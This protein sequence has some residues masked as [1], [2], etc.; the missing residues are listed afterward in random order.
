MNTAKAKVQ[1]LQFRETNER[2]RGEYA[3]QMEQLRLLYGDV[4]EFLEPV[5]AGETIPDCDA[6]VFPQL[7]GAAYHYMEQF[8]AYAKPMLVITSQFGTVDMW[9][10]ELITYMRSHGLTVFSPY[11]VEL[12]KVVMRAIAVKEHMK[13]AK[14]L[15]FQDDPGEGM[16]AYIFKRFYWWEEECTR[17]IEAA[18]GAK[19]LYR[20]WKAVNARAKEMDEKKAL[21]VFDSWDVPC[22]G[23]SEKSRILTGQ[24]YLAIHEVI[25]ELGGVDGIGANCLNES[26]YSETTP[27]LIWNALFE[28][29][30]IVWCC[31]GDTLSMVSTY[32]LY[33][34]LKAPV[35]MTNIYPFLVGKAA[36]YHEKIDDFP[37]VDDPA[38]YALGVHCGYAGFAPKCFCER[39]RALPK[40]LAIVNENA[41]VIDC[42]LPCGDMVLAKINPTFDRITVIPGKI[43]RYVQ[44]PDTDS[45]NASLLHY[46]KGEEVMEELPSHHQL[47]ITGKQKAPIMQ[48]AKVFGWELN[49]I[50]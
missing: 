35:M 4:A 43:E 48:V 17:Q 16:Q 31:E 3:Q 7:I 14:F 21:E 18:F 47:I 10:W 28:K 44:F 19:V 34:S 20:S 13:G 33:E 45:R 40:V 41:H 22:E 26:M 39:W 36:I 37:P 27:C 2:E 8:A 15:M 1:P 6:V 46:A 23:L 9:D 50:E 29:E 42:E 5:T 25:D 32:V 11:N 49:I 12:G 24:L 30:G 38:N